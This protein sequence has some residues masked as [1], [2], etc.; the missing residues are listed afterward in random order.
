MAMG[1]CNHCLEQRLAHTA[2][3][4]RWQDVKP[5]NASGAAVVCVGVTI[6]PTNPNYV[7]VN[8]SEK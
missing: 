6:K 8:D 2:A 3:P 1:V 5:P 7:A 4:M